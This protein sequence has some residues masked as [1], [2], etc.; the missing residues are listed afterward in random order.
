MDLLID[1]NPTSP[2]FGDLTWENGSLTRDF[3]TQELV[4]VVA[5]RLFILLRTFQEEW[6]LEE[7]Y[8]IPYWQ[9][10]LGKKVSKSTVDLIFQQKI[11]AEPG[12]AN[13]VS[14]K[15]Q[16]VNRRYS[17]EFSVRVT[18]GGITQPITIDQIG[19]S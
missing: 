10:I 4:E 3:T 1:K 14:F 7:P 17:M 11:L 12:V 19:V 6:F 18:D 13:I 9:R 8:G 5:Q 2:A 16:I 15:S